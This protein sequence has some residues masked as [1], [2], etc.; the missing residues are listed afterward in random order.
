M[1]SDYDQ[2]PIEELHIR[3]ESQTKIIAHTSRCL[4]N[5]EKNYPAFK[6]EFL[7]LKWAVKINAVSI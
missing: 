3:H 5:S 2:V 1:V 6:V 4:T 7:A